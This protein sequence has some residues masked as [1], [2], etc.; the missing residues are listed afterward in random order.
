MH[1][2]K[3]YPNDREVAN[4][5]GALITAHPCLRERGSD[6]GWY[7]W[8]VSLKFKMG[9]YR[10][11]LQDLGVQRY[12][13]MQRGGAKTTVRVSTPIPTVKEPDV[14]KLTSIPVFQEERSR[15][16]QIVQEFENTE[17]TSYHADKLCS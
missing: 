9:N 3:P 4:A 8:K 11:K 10:T 12:L 7:G 15:L 17:R 6:S 16:L 1:S 13:S 14:L 2:F 5:A